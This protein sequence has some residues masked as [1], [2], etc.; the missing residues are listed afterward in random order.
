MGWRAS[1]AAAWLLA[2]SMPAFASTLTET[3]VRFEDPV[4]AKLDVTPR[5]EPTKA[6]LGSEISWRVQIRHP[7]DTTIGFAEPFTGGPLTLKY[8]SLRRTANDQTEVQLVLAGLD[9][10]KFTLPPLRLR[11][12]TVDGKDHLF[13]VLGGQV[14][15][16]PTLSPGSQPAGIID[17]V[18]IERWNWPLLAITA[19]S[20]MTAIFL[21][22]WLGR[23]KLAK[24]SVKEPPADPRTPEQVALD[25]IFALQASGMLE[26]RE[27]KPFTYA[28]DDIVR[29]Y[30]MR[31]SGCGHESQTSAEFLIAVSPTLPPARNTAL[32]AFFEQADR[33]RF[34]G[35]EHEVA[36]AQQLCNMAV[37][38]VQNQV[39]TTETA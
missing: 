16:Q 36:E 21:A 33:V 7:Q 23:R 29:Q 39:E 4:V 8:S 2:V 11:L 15:I 13:N 17:P 12:T 1:T 31:V 28:L 32:R 10:G 19:A 26:R 5:I 27:I 24:P 30:V 14:E 3:T 38:L 25:A 6:V 35:E 18:P 20:L 9:L 34:A 22:Y 37:R